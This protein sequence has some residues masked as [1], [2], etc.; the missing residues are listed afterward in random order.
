[1]KGA[2]CLLLLKF[3]LT[4]VWTMFGGCGRMT[5]REEG[6]GSRNHLKKRFDQES[7]MELLALY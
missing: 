6:G 7:L 5:G 1:M 3:K 2:F 4:L